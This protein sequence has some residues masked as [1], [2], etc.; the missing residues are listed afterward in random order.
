MQD[1]A[2][3]V[4]RIP[5]QQSQ[6]IFLAVA[7]G[8]SRNSFTTGGRLRTMLL[9]RVGR[10]GQPVGWESGEEGGDVGDAA[11]MSTYTA[12]GTPYCSQ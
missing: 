11:P 4:A 2:R 7:S 10:V 12:L 5:R 1:A 3:Y 6:T 8:L 9:G